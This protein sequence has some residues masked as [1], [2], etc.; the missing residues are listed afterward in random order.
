MAGYGQPGYSG[1]GDMRQP[2]GSAYSPQQ[3]PLYQSAYDQHDPYAQGDQFAGPTAQQY[4]RNTG[5]RTQYQQVWPT[6]LSL[7]S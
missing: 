1:Q 7:S 4:G 2:G 3:Q 5:L 6:L